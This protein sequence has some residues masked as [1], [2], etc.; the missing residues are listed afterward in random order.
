MSLT[1]F[2]LTT[3]DDYI[4][5]AV[6]GGAK[7]SDIAI[8]YELTPAGL[9]EVLERPEFQTK[10]E[11]YRTRIQLRLQLN[12]QFIEQLGPKACRNAEA[13]LDNP[14]HREWA[15]VSMEVLKM[16]LP[17]RTEASGNVGIQLKASD[18]TMGKLGDLLRD[19]LDAKA[20]QPP[21]PSIDADPRLIDR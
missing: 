13:I 14:S 2:E 19:L 5:R 10:V 15:K 9:R 21:A 11:H 7:P 20:T 16:A 17:Q 6:A 18:E 12:E 1:A 4:A 3:R 8:A